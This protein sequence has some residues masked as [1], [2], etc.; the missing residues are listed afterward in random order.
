[1]NGK[2]IHNYLMA[3]CGEIFDE[4][5]V[6]GFRADNGKPVITG[7]AGHPVDS[8]DQCRVLGEISNYAQKK[9]NTITKK[10]KR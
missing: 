10:N 6:I 3:P 4:Y 1:M 9:I 5:M 8:A 7:N 2:Q